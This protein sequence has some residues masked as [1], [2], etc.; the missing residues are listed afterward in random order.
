MAKYDESSIKILEGLE[1][2]RKRPGMYIGS[3]DKRGLHHL[4][5]EIVDNGIDEAINGYGNHLTVIIHKDGSVSVSDEGRGVPVGK[6]ASGKSTPEVIYTVLHAGGKFQEGGYKVSGGLHGVGASVVNALSK[7][8]KVSIC[9]DG[10]KY[11]I[12]FKNGG[13]LDSDLKKV[14]TTNKTGTTVRF[15]PDDSIFSTTTFSFTT[16]CERMQ[17]SAFLIKGLKI[18]VIDEEDEKEAHYHYERGLEEFVSYLNEGKKVLHNVVGFDAVK[19]KIEVECDLQYTDSYSE[20]VVSFVNNVKTSDGGSHEVGLKSALT[21]VFND[22][23]KNNGY[24][25]AKD[26]NFEGTDV[27]EGLTVV[28]SL[29]IPEDLLQ[30]E[31]QTKGKLGTPLAKT[32]VEQVVYEKM[33]YFLEENKAVATDIINKALKGKAAREA[34]RKAREEARKG[35][36]KNSKEKNLSDKLAP[37]TKKNPKKN[38]LFIVEGDSAGGSAKTGRERSYQAILPLRGKVLNTERCT[39]D[40]AYKNAEINTLIY[41]IGA[42]VGSDF[43]IEDCNYDKIIIMTDADDD[44][45]HIQVLLVTFFYRY[46]RPLIEAGKVYIA[47]PPL[48][49]ISFGKKEE[50]YAYSDEELKELT[51]NRKTEDLQRY[52]GLGE[53]DANQLWETTM[54]PLKRSLIQVKITDVALAEKR[55]SILMGDKVEPRK[56]WIEENVDFTLEDNYEIKASNRG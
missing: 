8:M 51:K 40:E 3:T 7:W 49:K 46:M 31:G 1:A 12:S 45:C 35:K 36:T 22:Y 44:G 2:V 17:E 18:D 50:V 56:E 32:V 21:K 55:V 19:N 5:W 16:I 29:K 26:K 37:A 10:G 25:K 23:A 14:G 42:G 9:R 11:E 13:H 27:R 54:D 43:H 41:T 47:N 34:A 52:K 30:F 28:L 6:H 4:V 48:Y 39:M 53:M 38:E 24:L 20:N 33:Q 15:M